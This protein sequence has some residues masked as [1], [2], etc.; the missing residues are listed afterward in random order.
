[1]QSNELLLISDI[2][3]NINE[4]WKILNKYKL[5]SIQVGDFGFKKHHEWHLKNIDSTKHKI[6]FGNH[7][8]Y[9]FLCENHSLK[10]FSY[11]NGLMTVRGAFSIDRY[12]R[13]DGIDWWHNEEMTYSEMLDAVDCYME[14]KP[15]IMVTHD[16]PNSIR[17]TLFGIFDKSIT[18]NGLEMMFQF[19]KPKVWVFGHHHKNID[20]EI[21]G[22]RFICQEEFGKLIINTENYKVT[23]L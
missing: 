9:S 4:Y 7:D 17:Q 22:T 5:K 3:G 10:N 8:D 11:Y 12:R 20:V 6:N 1:M 19:H 16:C 23:K 15:N 18:A 2:H 14:N 13:I 21:M